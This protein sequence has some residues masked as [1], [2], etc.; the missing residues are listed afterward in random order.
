MLYP[1][2]MLMKISRKQTLNP[3]LH[4][5]QKRII[6]NMIKNSNK[7]LCDTAAEEYSNQT[8]VWPEHHLHSIMIFKRH[9]EI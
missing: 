8:L 5:V 4:L 7:D 9:T 6:K 1:W 3:N 2:K